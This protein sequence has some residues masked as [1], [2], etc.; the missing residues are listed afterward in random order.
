MLL[1][2]SLFFCCFIVIYWMFSECWAATEQLGFHFSKY[3][4]SLCR[5]FLG[6]LFVTL[7]LILVSLVKKERLSVNH[8]KALFYVPK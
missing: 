6:G 1:V 8:I 7:G 4:I 5:Y 3:K 2:I